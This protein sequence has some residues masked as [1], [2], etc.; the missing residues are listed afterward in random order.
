MTR[1]RQGLVLVAGL[2]CVLPAG[3][4]TTALRPLSA[5]QV[6]AARGRWPTVTAASLEEGRR[7]YRSRCGSCH[8]LIA[9]RE[10]SFERWES[11]LTT[12]A[13]EAKLTEE[14]TFAVRAFLWAAL[15]ALDS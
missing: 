4:A 3:C 2:F 12:M 10:H 5:P 7:L 6:S 1:R 9:P 11:E 8:R 15:Q 14:E 13:V